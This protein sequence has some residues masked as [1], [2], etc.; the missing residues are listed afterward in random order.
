MNDIDI[1]AA[2]DELHRAREELCVDC[3]DLLCDDYRP[4]VLGCRW[5]AETSGRPFDAIQGVART[6]EA[7]DFAERITKQE[8]MRCAVSLGV[9][10]AGILARAWCHRMQFFGDREKHALVLATGEEAT[11]VYMEPDEFKQLADSD[12]LSAELRARVRMIRSLCL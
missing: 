4:R 1:E 5:L 7:A 11:Q 10:N 2:L 9:Q 8:T 3:G 6:D 12:C